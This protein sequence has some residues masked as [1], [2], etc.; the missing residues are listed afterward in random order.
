MARLVDDLLDV[1]RITRGKIELRRSRIRLDEVVD[2][3]VEAVLPVIEQRGQKLHLECEREI[4]LYCDPQ[5]LV[6]A[7]GNVL[8]NAS[9]YTARAGHIHLSAARRG[10][11][12]EITVKDNGIGIRSEM[13]ER[14]FETFSQDQRAVGTEVQNGLGIGLTLTRT[15]IAMHG[16]QVTATSD[17]PGKGSC[18]EIRLPLDQVGDHEE[19]AEKLDRRF[20]IL[21]VDDNRD[22]AD[23][24]CDLLAIEGY[25]VE[26]AY[27]GVEA[28]RKAEGVHFHMILLDLLMPDLT[29]YEVIRRVRRHPGGP[30]I[31]AVTGHGATSDRDKVREAGFDEHI[32][33]PVVGEA[34]L[35]VVRQFLVGPELQPGVSP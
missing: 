2:Q 10:S 23:T 15:L 1:S 4:D 21:V 34:V 18:F 31:V 32:V 11:K 9:K 17:G 6:Q 7:L 33:K 26:T 29:G 20:R 22:A 3:A 24:M 16:G 14:I 30:V 35:A 12:V 28:L 8:N 5:R 27:G 13:L 25:S 19:I